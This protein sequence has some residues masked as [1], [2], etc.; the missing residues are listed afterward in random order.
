MHSAPSVLYP[1]GRP[2]VWGLIL[3]VVWVGGALLAGAWCAHQMNGVGWRQWLAIVCVMLGGTVAA[4]R[5]LATPAGDLQW[6]GVAWC[7]TTQAAPGERIAGR[8]VVYLDFQRW[9]LVRL[10]GAAGRPYWF[11][12]E[13]YRQPERWGD[14][15]RAVH[16]RARVSVDTAGARSPG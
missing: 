14:L 9:L 3:G 15:R 1:V 6:D 11:W 4:T 7:W 16:S 13:Q 5:W 10:S 2:R 12:L 8:L